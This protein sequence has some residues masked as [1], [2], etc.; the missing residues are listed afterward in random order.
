MRRSGLVLSIALS[1]LAGCGGDGNGNAEEGQG[2]G[3]ATSEAAAASGETVFAEAGCGGCHTLA[4]ANASGD[5]GPN[6]DQ[7]A[8]DAGRVAEQVRSGG[9]GMPSFADSLGDA[10]IEAVAQYVADSAG[11]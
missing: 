1:L 7:L 10:E 2:G 11:G 6:L 4:A 8:P 5:V 9:G 3:A